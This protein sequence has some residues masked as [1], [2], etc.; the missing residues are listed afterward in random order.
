MI[1]IHT[2][3]WFAESNPQ[4]SKKAKKII[5][6]MGNG[7]FISVASLWEIA[8]KISTGKLILQFRFEN[9]PLILETYQFSVLPIRF[10]HT[11]KVSSLNFHHRDPFD[12]I[13]IAQSLTENMTIVGKDRHFDKYGVDI[14]W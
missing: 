4:L 11:L 6:N 1:D 7:I 3:L 9:M 13:I 2:F 12:R 8:I 14:I 10:E 5:E